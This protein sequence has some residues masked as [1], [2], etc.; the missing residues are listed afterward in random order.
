[1][2]GMMLAPVVVTIKEVVEVA[3]VRGSKNSRRIH[4]LG[5]GVLPNTA[6]QYSNPARRLLH[7]GD[8]SMRITDEGGDLHQS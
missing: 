4:S 1:M 7:C 3:S 5:E 8:I 2:M 6:T